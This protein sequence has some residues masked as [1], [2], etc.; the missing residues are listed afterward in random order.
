V[1]Q[2]DEDGELACVD[3]ETG[4]L[5]WKHKLAPDQVHASPLHAD[6]KLYVP[7]NNGT[8]HIVAP[9]DDGP[10]I[11][12]QDQL[13]GNCLGAPALAN[14][15]L[16]VHTT[17]K[18]YCFAG[19]QTNVKDASVPAPTAAA[20]AAA[21]TAGPAVRLQIVPGDAVIEAGHSLAVRARTLDAAGR[22]VAD[23]A[24]GAVFTTTLPLKEETPGRFAVARDARAGAGMLAAEAAGLKAEA[25][26]RILA[27]L[28]YR[29]DFEGTK[30]DQ[31][32]L[33]A[34]AEERFG[35]PPPFWL[36]CRT[37][38]DVREKDGSQVLART[39]DN[40]LFQ[41]S[42]TL[43]GD[44]TDSNYTVQADVM[45][46]GNRRGLASVGVVNQRY[47]IWLKGNYGQL[48]VSSNFESLRVNAPCPFEADTWYTLKTRVDLQGDGSAIVRAKCWKR[49]DAEPSE[50][51]LEVPHE[52]AHQNGAAGVYGFTLMNRFKAYVDNV[53]VTPNE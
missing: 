28:P 23:P 29:E 35:F 30:L 32:K 16:Y 2:T 6:G 42:I 25:R 37:K 20:S 7:M 3:A 5:L 17:E 38:W 47:L 48:E 8:F 18:L 51:T 10:E 52:H 12:D 9:K 13:D 49:G 21:R 39:I 11:L 45:V 1:Y 15:K 33:D 53:Q 40:P 22:I 24:P 50:W 36:S 46:E 26:V 43:F 4:K 31:P 27:A 44:P 41:R 34:P 14:G 19:S